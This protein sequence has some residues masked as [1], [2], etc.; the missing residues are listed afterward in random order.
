MAKDPKKSTPKKIEAPKKKIAK[1]GA[2]D[3]SKKATGPKLKST[4]AHDRFHGRTVVITGGGGD[5]G[6]HCG[7]RMAKEGA[8]VVIIG[9]SQDSLNKAKKEIEKAAIGGARVMTFVADVTVVKEVESAVKAVEKEFK[10][11][12]YVFNNAGYQGSFD[13]VQNY[14]ADDF[15][16][17]MTTNVFGVFNV[18]K[19]FANHMI[20][21]KIK[22][23]IVNSSS[24]AATNCPPNMSA[25]AASKGA[26]WSFS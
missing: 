24:K 11:V 17:I 2:K 23:S 1:N 5:F 10:H 26:V 25:Y 13:M 6:K 4:H 19:A 7:I 14:D 9:R 15:M 21:H 16:K 3:T 12:H 8:N 18:L 20:K 22:G